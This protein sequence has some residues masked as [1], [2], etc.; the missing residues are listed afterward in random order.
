MRLV[1]LGVLVPT[2]FALGACSSGQDGG[3]PQTVEK[4]CGYDKT[5]LT[6]ALKAAMTQTPTVRMSMDLTSPDG[7]LEMDGSMAYTSAG[8]EMEMT[9]RGPDDE[10]ALVIVDGRYFLADSADGAY[11]EFDL[12]DPAMAPMRQQVESM[13]IRTTFDA[14][15][16]G[17][18]E[19]EVVG[20]DEIDGEEV[21]HYTVTLDVARAF[22]VSGEPVSPGMP[23][24]VDYELYLTTDD[25]M[26]RITFDLGPVDAEMNATR[27]NEPVDIEVPSGR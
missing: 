20:E 12:D 24:T 26:R 6:P 7:D 19:V 3:A 16:A 9:Y 14:W 4:T 5:T 17:L 23:D 25:L 2:I 21:C 1:A 13:D 27:W 22:A 11:R 18:E 15:D 10:F 8:V